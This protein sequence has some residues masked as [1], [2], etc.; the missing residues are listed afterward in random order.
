MAAQRK[1]TNKGKDPGPPNPIILYQDRF[2]EDQGKPLM[3]WRS[4][5]VTEC[6]GTAEMHRQQIAA[7]FRETSRDPKAKVAGEDKGTRTQGKV[8]PKLKQDGVGFW[9]RQGSLQS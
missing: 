5:E 4:E 1:K 3:I 8:S 9:R 7:T 6:K 2:G